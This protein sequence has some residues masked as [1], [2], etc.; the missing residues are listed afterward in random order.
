MQNRTAY[1]VLGDLAMFIKL[2]VLTVKKED[3]GDFRIKIVYTL[4]A[5][6]L[7][8]IK[9]SIL[10]QMMCTLLFFTPSVFYKVNNKYNCGD[11]CEESEFVSDFRLF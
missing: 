9:H 7:S 3:F 2:K 4:I 8:I 6:S 11:P 10:L 5:I 1:Y